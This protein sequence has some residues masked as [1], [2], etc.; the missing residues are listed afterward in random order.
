[1][2]GG[3]GF[4]LTELMNGKMLIG[5]VWGLTLFKLSVTQNSP[6][7]VKSLAHIGRFGHLTVHHCEQSVEINFTTGLLT[8]SISEIIVFTRPLVP[9]KKVVLFFCTQKSKAFFFLFTQ[10]PN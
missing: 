8:L 7:C 4:G 9:Q 6:Y 3:D 10:T 2:R 1:M 5:I